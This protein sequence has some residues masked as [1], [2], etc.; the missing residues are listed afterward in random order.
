LLFTLCTYDSVPTTRVVVVFVVVV[1]VLVVVVAIC[2]RVVDYVVDV[3]V[4]IVGSVD[5]VDV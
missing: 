3:G 4:V 1:V 2:V 5:G